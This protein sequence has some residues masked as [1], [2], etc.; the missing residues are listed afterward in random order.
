M[1]EF[2]DLVVLTLI[3]ALQDSQAEMPKWK[4][5]KKTAEHMSLLTSFI[6]KY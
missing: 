1:H 6:C 5:F 2:C 3:T 4:Q